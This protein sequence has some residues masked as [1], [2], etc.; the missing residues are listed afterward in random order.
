[1]IEM[2]NKIGFLSFI[3]GTRHSAWIHA[4][5]LLIWVNIRC[6]AAMQEKKPSLDLYS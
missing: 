5:T 1:M 3:A 2:S 6:I 4:S